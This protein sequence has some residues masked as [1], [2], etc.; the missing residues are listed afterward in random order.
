[1]D[2]RRLTIGEHLEELRYRL[3]VSLAAVL[4]VFILCWI[5]RIPLM[6]V[7]AAPHQ[8]TMRALGFSPDL[9]VT[10]Y[11]EAFITL[12]KVCFVA[13]LFVASPIVIFQL[14]MFVAAGLYDHEKKYVYIFAPISMGSFMLGMLFG[15]FVLIPFGLRFLLLIVGD[16]ATPIIKISDYISLLMLLTLVLGVVFQLP[17]ILLFLVKIDL[18]TPETLRRERRY[19]IL[20]AFLLAAILT[21]PDPGT[22][23]MLAI[24]ALALYEIGILVA[25][26]SWSHFL[27]FMGAVLAVAAIASGFILHSRAKAMQAGELSGGVAMAGTKDA[28]SLSA[29]AQ[30][31]QLRVGQILRTKEANRAAFHLPSGSELRMNRN[32]EL[33]FLTR[34]SLRIEKGEIWMAVKPPFFVVR[35]RDGTV[36][37]KEGQV[38]VAVG[39]EGTRLVVAKGAATASTTDGMRREI[40]AGRTFTFKFGGE[41]VDVKAVTGWT[42]EI[43]KPADPKPK[44]EAEKTPKPKE[45]AGAASDGN[46]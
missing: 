11:Q 27:K 44:T 37:I 4:V 6:N 14:W 21:P 40:L 20:A 32:T 19:A 1:M 26:P 43:Q 10:A 8:K 24:P 15:Y 34:T 7:L 41:P 46:P 16:V 36:E 3:V 28:P 18:V 35:T 9:K 42:R 2:E 22:Q 31:E 45:P 17:L 13:A 38:D 30:G 23:I 5:F 25:A 29:L 12:M 33:T 39:P